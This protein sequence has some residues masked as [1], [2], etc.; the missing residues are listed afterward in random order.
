MAR[1]FKGFMAYEPLRGGRRFWAVGGVCGRAN[2]LTGFWLGE[3]CRP[4]LG[5][6]TSSTVRGTLRQ[7]RQRSRGR[8]AESGV[9]H[10][11]SAA[12]NRSG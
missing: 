10:P 3:R 4:P 5:S 8:T 6:S 1:S 7:L 11:R 12:I 9:R 2:L